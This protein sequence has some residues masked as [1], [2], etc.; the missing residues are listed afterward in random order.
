VV[1]AGVRWLGY[2]PFN[3]AERSLD[4]TNLKYIPFSDFFIFMPLYLAAIYSSL[5]GSRRVRTYQLNPNCSFGVG[6]GGHICG[7][8]DDIFT[9]FHIQQSFKNVLYLQ[10]FDIPV[11]FRFVHPFL[12]LL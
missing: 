3:I 7:T 8:V 6:L 12:A 10:I 11:D 9:E 4:R 1:G 2:R 5:L